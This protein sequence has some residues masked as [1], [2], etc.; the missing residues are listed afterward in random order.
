[1]GYVK[2]WEQNKCYEL[3][4][5]NGVENKGKLAWLSLLIAGMM[6]KETALK[7]PD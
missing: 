1:M 6:L 3:W 7:T 2:H 5:T 4:L